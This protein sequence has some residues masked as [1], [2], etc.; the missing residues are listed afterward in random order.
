MVYYHHFIK[1]TDS[2]ERKILYHFAGSANCY[3]I[4]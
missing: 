3:N 4:Y 2:E 1:E